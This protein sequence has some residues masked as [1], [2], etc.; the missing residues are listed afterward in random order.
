MSYTTCP[1]CGGSDGQGCYSTCPTMLQARVAELEAALQWIDMQRY[2]DRS[3]I[4]PDNAFEQWARLNDQL[5]MIMD[6]ARAAL[7]PPAA[8][9]HQ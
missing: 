2:T 4:T 8:G 1:S 3:T 7:N 9:E 5:V 6:K